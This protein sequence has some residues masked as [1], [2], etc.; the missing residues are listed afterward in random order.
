MIY[1]TSN[2]GY[3]AG[4]NVGL[5]V[6]YEDGSDLFLISNSDVLVE[7]ASI[8]MLC[9][10]ALKTSGA[11]VVG[12]LIYDTE[13]RR[14]PIHMLSKLTAVGKIKNMLLSTPLRSLF[15]KFEKGFVTRERPEYPIKV[16]GDRKS[17]V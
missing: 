10:F 13:G 12:P 14:Q 16:F 3:A 11:G 5:K 4:N 7:D 9:D 1:N 2:S 15:R 8:D 17:V 6:A